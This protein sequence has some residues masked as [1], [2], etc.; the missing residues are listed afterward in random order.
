MRA[1][2]EGRDAVVLPVGVSLFKVLLPARIQ[3]SNGLKYIHTHIFH[4]VSFQLP[5]W[6]TTT[7]TAVGSP[8]NEYLGQVSIVAGQAEIQLGGIVVCQN[9]G[10][11]RI[12]AQVVISPSCVS[13]KQHSF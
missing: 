5:S 9:P 3:S 6:G 10:E 12:Q 13:E 1:V 7:T 2:V 8:D 11:H 4:M